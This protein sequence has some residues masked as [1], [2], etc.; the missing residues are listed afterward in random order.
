MEYISINNLSKGNAEIFITEKD[1]KYFWLV[2][3]FDELYLKNVK[4]DDLSFYT[5]IP[6][7]LYIQL[8]NLN[9]ISLDSPAFKMAE[10]IR[11]NPK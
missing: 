2:A 11:N 7:L 10:L 9:N 5:E 3:D 8:K 4:C 1:G 6:L